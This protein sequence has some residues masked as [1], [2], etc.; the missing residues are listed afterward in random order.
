MTTLIARICSIIDQPEV[1][2][3][4]IGRTGDPISRSKEYDKIMPLTN[5]LTCKEEGNIEGNLLCYFCDHPKFKGHACDA[6][7]D[8]PL[9]KL[10][11]VYL[12]LKFAK[13][14]GEI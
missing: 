2:G 4:W 5:Y 7:G 3:F 8:C 11:I 13:S 12:A 6:R 10:Q 14:G 1:K 9:N